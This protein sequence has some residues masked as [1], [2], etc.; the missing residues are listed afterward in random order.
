PPYPIGRSAPKRLLILSIIT[1]WDFLGLPLRWVYRGIRFYPKNTKGTFAILCLHP[2]SQTPSVMP[3]FYRTVEVVVNVVHRLRSLE[4][5]NTY[6]PVA[7]PLAFEIYDE[8]KRRLNVNNL[9][10]TYGIY[11]CNQD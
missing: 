8:Y 5:G 9:Q 3:V 2:R 11:C 6:W 10:N 4:D 7:M 1:L